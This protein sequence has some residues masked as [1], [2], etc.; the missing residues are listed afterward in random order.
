MPAEG[1]SFLSAT[2]RTPTRVVPNSELETRLGLGPGVIERLTGIRSRRYVSDGESLQGLAAEACREA[3]DKSGVDPSQI[4]SLIFYSDSPPIMTDGSGSRRVY[5]DESAHIQHLLRESGLPLNGKCVAIAG[6]CVSFLLALRMAT[7]LIRSGMETHILLAGAAWNSPF[8]EGADKNVA[9]TF[10]DGVAAGVIG[11]SS[12]GGLIGIHCRTDGHGYA[13]GCY[14][15]YR[16]LFID[17]KRVA[18]FAPLGF[19]GAVKGLLGET[20]L[21]IEDFDL[22][23]PHQ[24]GLKIIER[25][26]ALAEIPPEKVYLCLQ[27]VGN[28]GAPAV[29]LALARAIE[30]GRVRAGDLIMLVAFGTGWNYGAAAIRYDPGPRKSGSLPEPRAPGPRRFEP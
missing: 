18:E 20:G 16:T 6:S 17:R 13:A 3:L 19:Q 14:P 22:V 10:G 26:M 29:Q 15:D 12:A 5:Y 27:D 30:E 8:L 4:D 24:A 1:V 23:I 21:K 25:G 7:A 11:P 9:M 2:Y 28:T